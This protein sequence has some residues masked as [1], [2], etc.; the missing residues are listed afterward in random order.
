MSDTNADK[1]DEIK[2]KLEDDEAVGGTT[3]D[4][5]SAVLTLDDENG[6]DNE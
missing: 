4:E 2:E 5:D 1:T 3:N 6:D